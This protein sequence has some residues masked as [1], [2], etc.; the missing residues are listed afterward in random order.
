MDDF[1]TFWKSYPN[2]KSK[3]A[4]RRPF[5]RAMKLTTLETI[6]AAIEEYKKH[7]PGYC[8]FKHPSTWLNGEC[9]NDEWTTQETTLAACYRSLDTWTEQDYR[10][11]AET[12]VKWGEE[13]AGRMFKYGPDKIAAVK[14]RG[15]LQPR[16]VA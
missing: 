4:A 5:E 16:E 3:G 15:M 6:L 14:A 2:K 12:V 10:E 8:D 11:C 9:W 1:E 7:K 13:K